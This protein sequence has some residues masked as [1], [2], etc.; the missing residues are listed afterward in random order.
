MG[1]SRILSPTWL[2]AGASVLNVIVL[3]VYAWFTWG[4]WGETQRSARRTE[5]LVQQS[6]EDFRLRLITAF[7][8]ETGRT[9]VPTG[10]DPAFIKLCQLRAQEVRLLLKG[11][12]PAGWVKIEQDVERIEEHMEQR[13]KP[14]RKEP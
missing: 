1:D 12:F 5:E 8:E 6:R 7:L 4:I 2:M 13:Y 11:S 10:S 14:Y 9:V 3:G